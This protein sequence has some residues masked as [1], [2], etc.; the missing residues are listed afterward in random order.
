MNTLNQT[1]N[2]V[3]QYLL[4]AIT[5]WPAVL[6]RVVIKGSGY[7]LDRYDFD[8]THIANNFLYLGQSVE[9]RYLGQAC[10]ESSDAMIILR[11]YDKFMAVGN[12][13]FKGD[14]P[15]ILISPSIKLVIKDDVFSHIILSDNDK[16]YTLYPVLMKD[17]KENQINRPAPQFPV[18]PSPN[19]NFGNNF[20]NNYRSFNPST[21]LQ[22]NIVTNYLDHL[23][24]NRDLT[25]FP[26]EDFKPK[27]CDPMYGERI[28]II[29]GVNAEDIPKL[30][31]LGPKLTYMYYYEGLTNHPTN[32][33]VYYVLYG[34]N[35]TIDKSEKISLLPFSESWIIGMI[36]SLK[37]IRT[38]LY[39]FDC[40]VYHA[41]SEAYFGANGT[42]DE[43]RY[44]KTYF[45]T[46]A[47]MELNQ[48]IKDR[49]P[50]LVITEAMSVQ[51]TDEVLDYKLSSTTVINDL[52]I[53]F[54]N[55]K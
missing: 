48:C 17:I 34:D 33:G 24:R 1:G 2:N 54:Y 4:E 14:I 22:P 28:R 27:T 5:D 29:T 31:D 41:I 3:V 37:T 46:L 19:P 30:N 53:G 7:F 23:G 40:P 47:A 8:N 13:L 25:D 38:G 20:G 32:E 45:S 18:F 21:E 49:G 44:V 12:Y 35:L 10:L 26:L 15:D 51:L 52:N 39:P 42:T 6:P 16:E 11:T 9:K 55:K 50:D 36:S 43:K